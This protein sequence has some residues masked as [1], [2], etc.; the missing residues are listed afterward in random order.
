MSNNTKELL[1]LL[2]SEGNSDDEIDM[3]SGCEDDGGPDDS[4][5]DEEFDP[6]FPDEVGW[7]EK[8]K[9][10]CDKEDE[11]E[12]EEDEEEDDEEEEDIKNV[13]SGIRT[14]SS[15]LEKNSLCG[16]MYYEIYYGY[17]VEK[18]S[19]RVASSIASMMVSSKRKND[20][21]GELKKIKKI[22]KVEKVKKKSLKVGKKELE[23]LTM[24]DFGL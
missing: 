21:C 24:G 15:N 4:G 6:N 18:Y 20:G 12:D 5:D 9:S 7:M 10:K 14:A 3:G 23:V 11:E 8:N 19:S 1:D 13:N 16:V 22:K 17:D 2:M